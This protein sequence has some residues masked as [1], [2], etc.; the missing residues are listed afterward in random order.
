MPSTWTTTLPQGT[1]KIRMAP[2][3]LQDRWT[4][5]Q[6]GE[7][8]CTKWQLARRAGNPGAIPNS[9]LIFTKDGGAGWSELYYKDD[10]GSA[11]TTQI[12]QDGGIGA[13]TQSVYSNNIIMKPGATAINN[14]QQA[15]VCAYGVISSNGNLGAGS[16]NILATSN[17]TSQGHYKINWDFTP[18]GQFTYLPV[19]S[20]RKLGSSQFWGCYVDEQE[21]THIRVTTFEMNR[22][23]P[24]ETNIDYSD[25][26]FCVVVY[27]AFT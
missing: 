9:G 17:R 19:V 18:T 1:T 23:G 5:I 22:I 10:Q 3:I 21:L 27:G 16:Y 8:P 12:T 4:N 15:F 13:L 7:V 20:V 2:N 26:D 14:T 6:Q 24:D 11:K 25:A